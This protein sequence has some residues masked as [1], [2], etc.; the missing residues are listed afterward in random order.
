MHNKEKQTWEGPAQDNCWIQLFL[1]SWHFQLFTEDDKPGAYCLKLLPEKNCGYF[2][3]FLVFS[4]GKVN[5][6][7]MLNWSFQILPDFFSS[8]SFMQ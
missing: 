7:I 8:N 3:H 1:E 5:G 6:K 2:N 4:Y